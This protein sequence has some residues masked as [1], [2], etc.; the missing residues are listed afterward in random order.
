MSGSG[1]RGSGATATVTVALA[2]AAV[3]QV[4]AHGAERG[5]VMLLP[6]GYYQVGSALAVAADA[7]RKVSAGAMALWLI[8]SS[9]TASASPA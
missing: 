2:A 9:M 6:T 8:I 7:I 1:K 3:W 4:H 5:L